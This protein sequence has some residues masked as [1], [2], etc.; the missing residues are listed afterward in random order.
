MAGPKPNRVK[1]TDLKSRIMHLA[2]TSVYQ[3]KVQPPSAVD[4]QLGGLYRREGRDIDLLC[5]STTLPG[6]SLATHDVTSDYMGVTEKMAYRRLYDNQIDM[7]FYV[8]NSYNVIDFFDGWIDY[9]SGVGITASRNQYKDT[10]TGFR[11]VYPKGPTGYKTNI[12]VTKFEKDLKNRALFYTFIDAFPVAT[13]SIPIQYGSSEI[14]QLTV[15]FSYVRYVRDTVTSSQNIF[16]PN[17]RA[18][19]PIGTDL[20]IATRPDQLG[21]DL[22]GDFWRDPVANSVDFNTAVNT[23]LGIDIP[24]IESPFF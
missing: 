11:M 21:I 7:Q 24:R 22:S 1:T 17:G 4:A 8:D 19:F 16:D 23:N 13:N 6:N 3:V 12:F 15:S 2:Q 5:N 20:G 14:L 18:S 9:I 10:R